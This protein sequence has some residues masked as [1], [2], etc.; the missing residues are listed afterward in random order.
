MGLIDRRLGQQHHKLLAAE[1]R[2]VIPRA[3]GRLDARGQGRQRDVAH[4][5]AQRVVQAFEVVDVDQAHGQSRC[6]VLQ[7]RTL[8]FE[9]GKQAASIGHL[10]QHI[11]GHL[12]GQAPQLALQGAHTRL[13]RLCA[14]LVLLQALTRVR[15]HLVHRACI[16]QHGAHG[17][18]HAV[19][20]VGLADDIDMARNALAKVAGGVIQRGQ[21]GQHLLH[22]GLERIAR[23]V[24]VAMQLALLAPR[25]FD[26]IA[27]RAH[28]PRAHAVVQAGAQRLR[29]ALNPGAVLGE[30]GQPIGE[31]SAE[32]QQLL[33]QV[34]AMS[35]QALGA[36]AHRGHRGR[37]FRRGAQGLDLIGQAGQFGGQLG[38]AGFFDRQAFAQRLAEC[39]RHLGMLVGQV[40]P[41]RGNRHGGRAGWCTDGDALV[42]GGLV[43][44]CHQL[45]QALAQ[46]LLV[47]A[48]AVEHALQA[49]FLAR[50]G[51]QAAAALQTA[52]HALDGVGPFG[53]FARR[54][55]DAVDG[56]WRHAHHA[57][58]PRRPPG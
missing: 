47:A 42:A 10:R 58:Q 48:A 40:K 20:G 55:C 52:H 9:G 41:Q 30:L 4:R 38:G 21:I 28:R 29:L 44:R 13:Q 15:H 7:A 37:Q 33:D 45:T 36:A 1:A 53:A 6:A 3:Q 16:G 23:P 50:C 54:P 25:R 26:Q 51:P 46:A 49:V 5:V 12:V 56:R 11:G 8:Q 19:Q 43:P 27:G 39:G 57:R 24:A 14:C 17:L 35:E 31:G 18:G 34:V 22:H 2:Q 32:L